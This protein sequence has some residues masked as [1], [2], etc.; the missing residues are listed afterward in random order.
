MPKGG[1]TVPDTTPLQRAEAA[2]ESPPS[3]HERLTGLA[4]HTLK[5]F[6]ETVTAARVALGD[7]QLA[8]ASVFAVVNT[9]TAQAATRNLHELSQSQMREQR[10]L[11]TEPAI[12]R[13]VTEDDDGNRRIYFISRATPHRPPSDGS[14][15]ASVRA[16][17]GR[18]ASL[19]IGGEADL[20]VNGA[21]RTL[22]V[23]ERTTLRPAS[24]N[25]EWDSVNSVVEGEAFG[26]FTI[27]SFREFLR[28]SGATDDEVDLLEAALAEDRAAALVVEGL[29]RDAITKMGLRDLALLDQY[30]DEIFRLPIDTHLV[31][32]GPPGTG[33]T[34][35]L[36]K[37]LGLKLDQQ[38]LSDDERDSIGATVAGTA[39]HAESWIM[40]T[41][42]SLLK[43]YIKEAFAR[44]DI[45]APDER[46]QT[47]DDFRL[48]LARN[49]FGILRS[50]SGSGMFVF[51]PTLPSLK[52]GTLAE[53][54]EWFTDFDAWQTEFFWSDLQAHAKTLSSNKA[55]DIARLGARLKDALPESVSGLH[56]GTFSSLATLNDEV[57]SFI[58]RLKDETDK[59]ISGAIGA[60][61]KADRE[62]LNHL[63]TFVAT[64]SE[65]D[66]GD[67]PDAEEEDDTRQIRIGRDAAVEA[68]KRALR[69]KARAAASSRT[70]NKQSRNGK[71]ME[72]FGTRG[73]SSDELRA[74]GATLHI[75]SAA[76]RFL[77][78]LRRF[79]DGLPGRY[80]RYRRERQGEGRWYNSDGFAATDLNPLEV[81]IIL[82][83]VL[84]N[85]RALLSDRRIS[86]DFAQG[87]YSALDPIRSLYRNQV[88]VD[89]ATDFSPVQLSCMANLCDPATQ[90]FLAC[91]DFN[92]RITEWGSR[93]N[94]DLNWVF[95]D[96]DIRPVSIT[97]RHSRQ[98]NELARSIALLSSPDVPEALLPQR[99]NNDGFEPVLA[100]GL[101]GHADTAAWLGQRIAEIERLTQALP[102]I[103]VLVHDEADV[104][105]LAEA[106]NKVL[107]AG[108]IRAV[109]C[110]DGQ[111]AGQDNDVRV[112]DVK[113]IK[114]L[115]FEAVFF[116]GIDLLAERQPDLFEKYLYVGAT[117]AA[118]YL[119]MTTSGPDL[120]LKV[121]ALK[122]RFSAQWP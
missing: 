45:A 95:P 104:K 118:M 60:E 49:K 21:L 103:A 20:P 102:P 76:R 17:A 111:L 97:Y 24:A 53:Q 88:M 31:I 65:A 75:Q 113:H 8:T 44:E 32:L 89:E 71:L 64:L 101:Y 3:N 85:G 58:A 33:K 16:P 47:W 50:A 1:Q 106:L 92:Q 84:K 62:F 67:D 34:T 77:N 14:L 80:R 52:A 59:S 25:G 11:C 27:T 18:L 99:V 40:F 13:I 37:R 22:A 57:Q 114:G 63:A 41:P 61:L 51:K 110:H 105:P 117:R 12:A 28:S 23:I 79:I 122:E 100:T 39:R 29:R 55:Q 91:G 38:H 56:T 5:H 83:G 94:D 109:P 43:Q 66:E 42:T 73:P 9:L 26:P 4:D 46:I 87:R 19:P 86:R 96:F 48:D 10:H 74:L 112:F 121:A 98:L 108:N 81:D 6:E 116:V 107:A 115:E 15:A 72:W 82:L 35:T 78:P 93:S 69:A 70:L 30:Q 68:L 36:I 90:S 2:P 120:P 7:A 54:K 119:G